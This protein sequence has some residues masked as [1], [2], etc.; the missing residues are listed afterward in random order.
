M[1]EAKEAKEVAIETIEDDVEVGV[2]VLGDG[3]VEENVEAG[4]G[5]EV[6]EADEVDG[7]GS[8]ED[9]ETHIL[10]DAHDFVEDAADS[11]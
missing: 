10:H 3:E 8:G 11:L 7:E 1:L 2:D 4:E 9:E 6:D 5:E